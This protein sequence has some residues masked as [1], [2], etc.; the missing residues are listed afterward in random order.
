MT[1][2]REKRNRVKVW[3]WYFLFIFLSHLLNAQRLLSFKITCHVTLNLGNKH[4]KKDPIFTEPFL[5]ET[6]EQKEEVT[7]G[8]RHRA[9]G[10][11]TS[12]REILFVKRVPE[13]SLLLRQPMQQS[14][15]SRSLQYSRYTFC[16]IMAHV[17][18]Y[19]YTGTTC[20]LEI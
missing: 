10:A 12:T 8:R 1:Q 11:Q 3:Q 9:K 2:K 13:R 18:I 20:T 17:G 15:F 6:T 5:K 4:L 7:K 19:P 16:T 14:V